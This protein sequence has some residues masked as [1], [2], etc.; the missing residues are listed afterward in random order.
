MPLR[1]G[2]CEIAAQGC[3]TIPPDQT[4]PGAVWRIGLRY[5]EVSKFLPAGAMPSPRL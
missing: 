2:A 5:Q 4:Q 1:A 3:F